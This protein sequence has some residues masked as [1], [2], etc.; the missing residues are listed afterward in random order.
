MMHSDADTAAESIL[1]LWS[2][3]SA[4]ERTVR[5]DNEAVLRLLASQAR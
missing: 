3:G 4:Q 1:D 2:L 5:R